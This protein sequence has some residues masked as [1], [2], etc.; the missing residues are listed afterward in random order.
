MIPAMAQILHRFFDMLSKLSHLKMMKKALS[1][2]LTILI[3]LLPCLAT[4][5]LQDIYTQLNDEFNTRQSQQSGSV[6]AQQE[7]LQKRKAELQGQMQSLRLQMKQMIQDMNQLES[8][9]QALTALEQPP[10]FN[11][12]QTDW[13]AILAPKIIGN[14]EVFAPDEENFYVIKN[15]RGHTIR[16]KPILDEDSPQRSYALMQTKTVDSKTT[17]YVE[18]IQ[19]ALPADAKAGASMEAKIEYE[20]VDGEIRFGHVSF[21]GQKIR[22]KSFGRSSLDQHRIVCLTG[23]ILD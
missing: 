20:V 22:D 5:D 4:A 14:C 18:I 7:T 2:F 3:F 17:P 9:I 13:D 19:E 11:L 15:R 6:E 16:F 10:R 23:V 12:G 8:E 21:L 1:S